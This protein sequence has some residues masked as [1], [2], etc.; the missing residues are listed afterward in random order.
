MLNGDGLKAWSNA[1]ADRLRITG[2]TISPSFLLLTLISTSTDKLRQSELGCFCV[3]SRFL[4]R[5]YVASYVWLL[6]RR[7]SLPQSSVLRQPLIRHASGNA[8]NGP[9]YHNTSPS[10][11]LRFALTGVGELAEG[12]EPRLESNGQIHELFSEEWPLNV[13]PLPIQAWLQQQ[14]P[15]WSSKLL[16]KYL[17]HDVENIQQ[18]QKFVEENVNGPET[19]AVLQSTHIKLLSRALERCQRY[20]S[21]GD[22]LL[23][24]NGII[25][26]LEKLGIPVSRKF[27]VLGMQY[28]CHC[29]SLSALKRHLD[30][31]CLVSSE[32]LDPFTSVILANS[33]ISLIDAAKIDDPDYN[34][35]S[36]LGLV[37]GESHSSQVSG[38]KLHD[39][40]CWADPGGPNIFIEQYALL[41]TKL[42]S[43][44]TFHKAWDR[45]METLST[46]TPLYAFHSA[47][48]CVLSLVDAGSSE[49]AV[50]CLKQISR[51]A[52][53]TLPEISKFKNLSMLLAHPAVNEV[54]PW[55]AGEKEL[56]SILENQLESMEHSLG[57]RWQPD[58]SVHSS[59]SDPLCVATGQPLF[60]MDGDSVG[61]DTNDRLI[62]E[63][64]SLGCS[65]S[66]TDLGI[67][68]N[69][70]D[71]HDGSEILAS[72]P[73]CRGTPLE[74]AWL[75]H[76]SPLD[77]SRPSPD[78]NTRT[79]MSI[80]W[81]P[82]TLGLI[83]VRAL[84]DESFLESRVSLH[85]M[86]LGYLVVR[87]P[88][89]EI[90]NPENQH[91][92][93]QSGHIVALDRATGQFLAL[94]VGSY[95]ALLEPGLHLP[96]PPFKFG[97]GPLAN[98]ALPSCNR[99][100]LTP[101]NPTFSYGNPGTRLHLEVDPGLGL[102]S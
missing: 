28:A 54:L 58:K 73:G 6:Q 77:F 12:H 96:S 100:F 84:S 38:H 46:Q 7:Q 51:H 34:V 32:R 97:L 92:W 81:S 23:A 83:R 3:Q 66:P 76:R 17:N 13:P 25:A 62:A 98:L 85:L 39:I 80:P 90:E 56:L 102:K 5:R 9:S 75:P 26:R 89:A 33:L 82:L 88:N 67:I 44:E 35:N 69:L 20:N 43:Q 61:F 21:C 40:L 57:I 29:H 78:A 48:A 55:L 31:Y 16:R 65:N 2:F 27:H 14:T 101:G 4:M 71:E 11:L 1:V 99:S 36:V 41:L 64:R 52:G 18:L 93:Q 10:Q 74:L 68:A 37:A 45:F 95:H 94:S 30:G 24:I 79:D 49:A 8:N 47:Y 15:D 60:T 53:N 22:I 63:V 19:A 86:Q 70:L 50:N 59:I 91:P 72:L 42:Q 87:R